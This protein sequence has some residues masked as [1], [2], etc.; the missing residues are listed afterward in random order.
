MDA[1]CKMRS[2]LAKKCN[3][4]MPDSMAE[5]QRKDIAIVEALPGA[6][7]RGLR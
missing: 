6:E 3:S 1:L 5:S 7:E 2:G 4:D